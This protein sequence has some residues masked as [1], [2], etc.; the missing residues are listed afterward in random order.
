[1]TEH[2]S[3]EAED[4]P[5]EINVSDIPTPK[6][7]SLQPLDSS[8]RPL[9]CSECRKEVEV[10]YSEII[11]STI[12]RTCMCKECP[13]LDQRLH[14]QLADKATET[15]IG[16]G[17]GLCCGNCDTTLEAVRT[18]NP[19]GCEDCYDV[20]SDVIVM[21]M[22]VSGKIS[23]RVQMDK[24]RKS[25]PL[26]I[27]YAPGEKITTNPSLRLI[28]LNEA[29]NDTLAREEYEQAAWI[30]DQI[31]ELEDKSEPENQSEQ[32]EQRDEKK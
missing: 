8:E 30:R 13:I 3:D 19:L 23:Q 15:S 28:A 31:K 9:E 16:M 5:D 20:F 4:L 24:S 32:A 26:H 10:Y 6:Q 29:L 18:G 25:V 12:I 21:E 7:F 2:H 1:M 17:A 11:G 27:G 22:L 14:G